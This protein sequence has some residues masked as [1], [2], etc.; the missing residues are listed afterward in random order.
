MLMGELCWRQDAREGGKR[1][2]GRN[3]VVMEKEEEE[4][5]GS[6]SYSNEEL[7]YIFEAE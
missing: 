6:F 4:K 3:Y 1:R 2:E 5:K 7:K